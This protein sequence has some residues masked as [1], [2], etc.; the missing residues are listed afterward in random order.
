MDTKKN[1]IVY[2]PKASNPVSLCQTNTG[3]ISEKS[4]NEVVHSETGSPPLY[5]W[6]DVTPSHKHSRLLNSSM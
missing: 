5:W 6:V 4:S 1:I 2:R 3:G